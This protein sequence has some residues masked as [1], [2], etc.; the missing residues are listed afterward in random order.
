MLQ[1]ADAFHAWAAPVQP[2]LPRPDR[3]RSVFL[4]VLAGLSTLSLVWAF[5]EICSE[6][7]EGG[8]HN[9]DMLRSQ[10][11]KSLQAGHPWV[12]ED[13]WSGQVSPHTAIACAIAD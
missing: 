6:I 9:L 4:T 11:A 12:V 8:T 2:A 5:I 1:T 13:M 10:S 3:C 7:I